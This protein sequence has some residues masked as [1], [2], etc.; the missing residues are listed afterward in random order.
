MSYN[1]IVMTFFCRVFNS[2]LLHMQP[3]ENLI[4]SSD[5]TAYQVHVYHI[6]HLRENTNN[7]VFYILTVTLI[8]SISIEANL[9]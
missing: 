1:N 8:Q 9:V 4:S 2:I 5:I 6:V 3:F 7:Q